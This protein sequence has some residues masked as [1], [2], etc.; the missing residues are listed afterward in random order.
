LCDNIN[1][2]LQIIN[3]NAQEKYDALLLLLRSF[4]ENIEKKNNIIVEKLVVELAD[5][6]ADL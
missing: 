3:D 4:K 5:I 6:K 2:E 1:D